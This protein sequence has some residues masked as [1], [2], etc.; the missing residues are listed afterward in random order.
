MNQTRWNPPISHFIRVKILFL[1][2]VA[3]WNLFLFSK[4][5]LHILHF[6]NSTGLFTKP[7]GHHY[8]KYRFSPD[9]DPPPDCMLYISELWPI[10]REGRAPIIFVGY[11]FY[12]NPLCMLASEDTMCRGT[13]F[14][15]MWSTDPIWHTV[16]GLFRCQKISVG[17]YCSAKDNAE[18]WS[19]LSV[20]WKNAK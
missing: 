20:V 4:H 10:L 6:P 9:I 5:R 19:A 12:L 11:H 14:C 13:Y 16:R 7:T 1:K 18:I 8:T 15:K 2:M 3:G 17:R